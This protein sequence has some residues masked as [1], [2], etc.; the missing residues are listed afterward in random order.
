MSS[1]TEQEQEISQ[2]DVNVIDVSDVATAADGVT[3]D[4]RESCDSSV[5]PLETCFAELFLGIVF[6]RNLVAWL[7]CF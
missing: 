2:R 4:G 7:F 3:D 5:E 1:L 6:L